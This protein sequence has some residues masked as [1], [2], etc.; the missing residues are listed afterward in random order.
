MDTN[1][2]FESKQINVA[3]FETILI[4]PEGVRF[5]ANYNSNSP[6]PPEFI[7]QEFQ[8]NPKSFFIDVG[9]EIIKEVEVQKL[10]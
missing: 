8:K 3:A 10:D 6:A 4:S 7:F 9:G 1:W 5:G 2:K